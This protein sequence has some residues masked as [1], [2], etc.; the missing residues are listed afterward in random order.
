MILEC[1][2]Y[3]VLEPK[4]LPRY[5]YIL[6]SMC[7]REFVRFK[8]IL[9]QRVV[10]FSRGKSILIDIL[11]IFDY[12]EMYSDI[13]YKYNDIKKKCYRRNVFFSI[14][15]FPRTSILFLRGWI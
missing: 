6:G 8:T 12:L 2:L 5:V 4:H 10:I 15:I 14:E 9:E 1:D 3:R 7:A 11:I 13:L